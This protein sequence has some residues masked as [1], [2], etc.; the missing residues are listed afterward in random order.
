MLLILSSLFFPNLRTCL[1][2]RWFFIMSWYVQNRVVKEDA[3]SITLI[4]LLQLKQRF[5]T[6]NPPGLNILWPT[7]W[8]RLNSLLFILYLFFP[9]YPLPTLLVIIYI[10]NVMSNCIACQFWT[11]FR[12]TPLCVL[13]L[14]PRH[15]LP[16]CVLFS[17]GLDKQTNDS[18]YK[19]HST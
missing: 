3:L 18:K 16:Y 2:T 6:L 12:M 13:I 8:S 19:C 15:A 17:P 14:S 5:T 10:L 11:Y 4:S 7:L 1:R 9:Q